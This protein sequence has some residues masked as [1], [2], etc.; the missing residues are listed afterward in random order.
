M[1]PGALVAERHKD[2]RIARGFG[3]HHFVSQLPREYNSYVGSSG[4][5]LSSGQ[6]QRIGIERAL[7]RRP[8]IL[9][10]DEAT[11][12]LD[13]ETEQQLFRNLK[14][15]SRCR[16]TI[17][18]THRLTTAKLADHILVFDRGRV[19]EAGSHSILLENRGRY[20]QM[21]TA[22]AGG[23]EIDAII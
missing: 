23:Q 16:T 8:R 13:A 19:V 11:S 1:P 4:I 6:R 12:N 2:Q 10:L 14:P 15:D 7:F 20:F 21:W 17:V 5:V 3:G 22:F 9:V 18:I